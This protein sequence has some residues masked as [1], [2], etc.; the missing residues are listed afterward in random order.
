[1]D[2]A[3][4]VRSVDTSGLMSHCVED[5]HAG[6]KQATTGVIYSRDGIMSRIF[7]AFKERNWATIRLAV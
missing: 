3:R 2:A 4:P 6:Q 7:F 1:M 5:C